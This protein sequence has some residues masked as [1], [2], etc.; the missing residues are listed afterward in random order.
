MCSMLLNGAA[1]LDYNNR[2]VEVPETFE[3]EF[4]VW[5]AF[6]TTRTSPT[7]LTSVFWNAPPVSRT[8]KHNKLTIKVYFCSKGL[9]EQLSAGLLLFS[10]KE[11][12]SKV[13]ARYTDCST[14]LKRIRHLN[15]LC[16]LTSFYFSV[17][18]KRLEA[19]CSIQARHV[20]HGVL[21]KEN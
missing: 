7:P 18:L 6:L 10:L 14:G 1:I 20:F 5:G 15:Y 3:L 21:F 8:E 11:K 4:W 16:I 13:V 9:V 19:G 17:N 12:H 2:F